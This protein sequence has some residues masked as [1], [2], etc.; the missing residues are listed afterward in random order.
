MLPTIRTLKPDVTQLFS[1]IKRRGNSSPMVPPS[2]PNKRRLHGPDFC[3]TKR[4]SEMRAELLLEKGA[5]VDF[6]TNDGATALFWA[7]C[8]GHCEIARALLAKGA[9]INSVNDSGATALMAA[10]GNNYRDIVELLIK[11]GANVNL[12]MNDGMSAV[13]LAEKVEIRAL[14]AG[15]GAIVDDT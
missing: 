8:N 9:D 3:R 14:L 13:R 11:G 1:R 10:A 12:K 4:S 15:A 5:G 7:A 2:T 6:K